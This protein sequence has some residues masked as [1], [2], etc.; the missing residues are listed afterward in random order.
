MSA[1]VYLACE[2]CKKAVHIGYIVTIRSNFVLDQDIVATLPALQSFINDHS[3]CG[4]EDSSINY[5]RIMWEPTCDDFEIVNRPDDDDDFEPDASG[6][7][8]Q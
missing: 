8:E 6:R 7:A 3:Y 1:E 5:P 4:P 2:H